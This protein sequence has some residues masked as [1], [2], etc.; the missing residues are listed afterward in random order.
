MESLA[1]CRRT[2]HGLDGH[3]VKLA[4]TWGATVLQQ[5]AGRGV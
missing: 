2:G 1:R 5:S 4:L 3:D